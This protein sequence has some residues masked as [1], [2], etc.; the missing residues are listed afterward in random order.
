VT[1]LVLFILAI[2]WLAVLLPPY[3]QN[4]SEKRPADSISSFQRQLSVLERR[5]T[6]V[7]VT[8]PV[9][10][11]GMT[12]TEARKRRRDVLFTLLGAASI[13]LAMAL[14]MGGPVWGLQILCDALVAGY[15]FLL[16]QTQQRE[17]ERVTKVRYLPGGRT[18]APEPALLLRRSGS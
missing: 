11:V 3:L 14:F 15:V 13:T 4:R 12:R 6:S 7:N 18:G 17:A 8:G 9:R 5:S 16:V 1:I 10:P 2:I